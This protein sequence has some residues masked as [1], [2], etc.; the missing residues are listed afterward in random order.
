METGSNVLRFK[1]DRVKVGKMDK[2]EVNDAV[3]AVSDV[4]EKPQ[5]K[6]L[7][8]SIKPANKDPPPPPVPVPV[9]SFADSIQTISITKPAN[10]W[11]SYSSVTL[12]NQM[13]VLLIND[14]LAGRSAI[15]LAVKAG[16][17]SDP[18]S[19][20]DASLIVATYVIIILLVFVGRCSWYCSFR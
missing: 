5:L 6:S 13:E 7:S 17:T 18:V 19:V 2:M 11:R 9:K 12:D 20:Y 4:I 15:S 16:W 1:G 10:D 8:S 3:M 14:A